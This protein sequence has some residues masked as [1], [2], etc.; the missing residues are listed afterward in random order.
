MWLQNANERKL[1]KLYFSKAQDRLQ[2]DGLLPTSPI[3][4]PHLELVADFDPKS[5]IDSNP[6]GSNIHFTQNKYS[7]FLDCLTQIFALAQILQQRNL[8]KIHKAKLDY[9]G[10]M[11]IE[12]TLLGYD[13]GRKYSNKWKSL[14]L[15]WM[16]YKD[17]FLWPIIGFLLGCLM[18]YIIT[19]N[20]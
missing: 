18:T 20:K 5:T 12:L 3:D 19:R 14:H 11:T 6:N 10:T 16:E 8:L 17:N 9:N 4:Y 1:I 15:W 13:L 2:K 7:R